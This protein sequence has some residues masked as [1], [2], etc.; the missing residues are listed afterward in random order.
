LLIKIDILLLPKLCKFGQ[1]SAVS[2]GNIVRVWGQT[3]NNR[4]GGG[5]SKMHFFQFIQII[6]HFRHIF[7]QIFIW[8]HLKLL[9]IVLVF[10]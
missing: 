9:R 6:K 8:N 10:R 4:R 1:F 7:I 5:A 2:F 3:P